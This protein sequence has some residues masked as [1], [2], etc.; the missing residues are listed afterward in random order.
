MYKF[1]CGRFSFICCCMLLDAIS[2]LVFELFGKVGSN[3]HNKVNY[4]AV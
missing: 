2:D 3:L 4:L 1:P